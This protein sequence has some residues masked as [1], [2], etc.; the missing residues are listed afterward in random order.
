VSLSRDK[1]DKGSAPSMTL[2]A[3]YWP[4]EGL[5]AFQGI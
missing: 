4:R 2:G 3:L 1:G 5:R